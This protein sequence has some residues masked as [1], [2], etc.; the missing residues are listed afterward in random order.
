MKNYTIKLND[1]IRE[2]I[3]ARKCK[4]YPRTMADCIREMIRENPQLHDRAQSLKKDLLKA[5]SRI[6]VLQRDI[7]RIYNIKAI[8]RSPLFK[9]L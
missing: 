9:N 1:K 5:Q 2:I 8:R 4:Y 3:E 7:H 6:E